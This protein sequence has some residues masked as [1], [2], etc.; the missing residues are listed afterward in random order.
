MVLLLLVI[1]TY[2]NVNHGLT[3]ADLITLNVAC[4]FKADINQKYRY[5][6]RECISDLDNS[7]KLGYSLPANMKRV[8]LKPNERCPVHF[9]RK[10]K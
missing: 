6:Q 9:L 2:I 5:A 8:I 4:V 10:I 3:L 7:V 1:D